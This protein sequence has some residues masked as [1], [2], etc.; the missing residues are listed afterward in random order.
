MVD[1]TQVIGFK[2]DQIDLILMHL[3]YKNKRESKLAE[4]LKAIKR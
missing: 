1:V 3:D 4:N 2:S